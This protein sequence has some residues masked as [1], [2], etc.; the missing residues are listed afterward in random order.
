[1]A[2]A[3]ELLVDQDGLRP[4]VRSLYCLGA[5]WGPGIAEEG[6]LWRLALP[7]LLHASIAHLAANMLFQLR[8]GFLV[9]RQ[10]GSLRFGAMYFLSG[11]LGNLLSAAFDPV[12]LAVGA[13]TSGLGIL[14]ST[15]A[16]LLARWQEVP[17]AHKM[18]V[19]YAAAIVGGLLSSANMDFY[20]HLGGFIG[21]LCLTLLLKPDLPERSAPLGCSIKVLR[22]LAL[23]TLL[24]LGGKSAILIS[25]VVP[26]ALECECPKLVDVLK[27]CL[28]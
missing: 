2:F 23:V 27:E 25:A 12:K 19:V 28:N 13:S 14:G 11:I 6:G 18:W 10:L 7:V 20:G 26:M 15:V 5:N 24:A 22:T 17:P 8:L 9:E 3:V 4:T 21:G 1:L 16:L